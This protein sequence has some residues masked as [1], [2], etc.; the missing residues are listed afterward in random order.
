VL[1][2][3]LH[4]AEHGTWSDARRASASRGR[5]M[6]ACSGRTDAV[7]VSGAATGAP[8]PARR[9]ARLEKARAAPG[10]YKVGLVLTAPATTPDSMPQ[11]FWP[12]KI[13]KDDYHSF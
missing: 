9:A 12:R 11:W 7:A 5:A 2:V 3:L 10:A 4:R 13:L 1:Y 6:R 8:K